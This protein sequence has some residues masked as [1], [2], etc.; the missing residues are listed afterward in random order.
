MHVSLAALRRATQI[1]DTVADVGHPGQLPDL[2][3]PG[4]AEMVGGD[5]ATYCEIG[6]GSELVYR[7]H[8]SGALGSVSLAGFISHSH[9]HPIIGHQ[10]T[11]GDTSAVT[12]SDF[13]SRREL[14]RLGLYADY[15]SHLSLEYQIAIKLPSAEGQLRGFSL[16]RTHRD[17]TETERSVLSVLAAPLGRAVRR[18]CDR[19]QAQEALGSSSDSDLADLTDRELEV[20]DLAAA[21]RTNQAIARALDVSPRTVAKHLE[22]A[23]RKLGVT[24]RAAAAARAAAG[25]ATRAQRRS[26]AR[27]ADGQ[28]GS[29]GH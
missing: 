19:Q 22:H 5:I 6:P 11:T 28:P 25:A 15:L 8:P 17:F 24:S 16:C 10:L 14:H 1:L 2:V 4:L 13:V 21:G 9:E 29:S 18:A 3:L 7:D 12:I 20:L 23:Y 26:H 27:W